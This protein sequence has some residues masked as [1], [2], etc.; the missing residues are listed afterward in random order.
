MNCEDVVA[1][2]EVSDPARAPHPARLRD[3]LTRCAPCRERYPDVVWLF[4]ACDA[5]RPV[6]VPALPVPR[7]TSRF[8]VGWAAAAAVVLIAAW[9]GWQA[10]KGTE[11]HAETDRTT[12]RPIR[13]AVAEV[14][15]HLGGDLGTVSYRTVTIDRGHRQGSLTMTEV[16]PLSRPM[17]AAGE[18][19]P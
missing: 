2:L 15:G 11:R 9:F 3:H 10:V 12:V 6:R 18:T 5:E 16:L 8:K 1:I 17:S 4:E 19:R 14:R 13:P 7:E